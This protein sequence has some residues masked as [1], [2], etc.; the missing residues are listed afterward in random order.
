MKPMGRVLSAGA[1]V[2]AAAAA[3]LLWRS[4]EEAAPPE[5]A[6]PASE[7]ASEP[8]SVAASA[9]SS[10]AAAAS[11]PDVGQG[12]EVPAAATPLA[13]ADIGT[14]LTDLIG[15]KA[16]L[17]FLQVDDFARRLVAT[18]DNLGR[19]HAP[20]RLW[21]V[22]PTPGRFM[23]E[24]HEGDTAIAAD[25]SLRYTPFVLLVETV[26]VARAVDLYVRLYPELQK[27]YEALGYPHGYFNDRLLQVIDQFLA[28]PDAQQPIR[29]QLTEVKGPIPA[30]QPWT[31]YEFADP[32]LEALSAGQK[33]LLRTGEVNARRLKAKLAEFR[34]ELLR[35]MSPR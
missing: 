1:I 27:S 2:A 13:A 16:V 19:T 33:L 9:A 22:N 8:P 30:E 12:A 32:E 31:R 15:R 11:L 21:P 17:T 24:A 29:V 10:A 20:S 14:A 28:T 4:H 6:Q 35:R 26:D 7:A 23:V 5:P 34:K 3:A 25:N 18:V